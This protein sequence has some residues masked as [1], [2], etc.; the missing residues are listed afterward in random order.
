MCYSW[1]NDCLWQI[2][3]SQ[4]DFDDFEQPYIGN[5]ILGTRFDKLV[6]GTDGKPLNTLSRAVYDNGRQLLLPDWNH[7][8]LEA[9]GV[10][11]I[12]DNGKH[13][14]EQ[15]MD[16]RNAVVSMVDRWEYK[17]GK[18]VVVSVEMFIPRT[19]GHASY[20]SFGIENL[21]EPAS[22]KFGIKEEMLLII[23]G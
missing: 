2:R 8:S 15:V 11:Y 22:L 16:I 21:N 20:L 12:P 10:A 6:A 7:I 14:L 19:F 4:K 17:P 5:G 23:I 13:Q 1:K 18:T 3:I 9:G